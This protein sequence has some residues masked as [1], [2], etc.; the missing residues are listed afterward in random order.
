[1]RLMLLISALLVSSTALAQDQAPKVAPQPEIVEE[2]S[3][4]DD[5][6]VDEEASEERGTKPT[7][8]DELKQQTDKATDYIEK[9]VDEMEV[10]SQA[11]RVGKNYYAG[12]HLGLFDFI[13]LPKYG[14]NLGV[15]DSHSDMYELEYSRGSISG[16][17][18]FKHLISITEQRLSLKKRNY[19]RGGSFNV[20]YGVFYNSLEAGIG[21]E[22]IVPALQ[23][24]SYKKVID[25]QALGLS[26][27][28]ANTWIFANKLAVGVDWI[29]WSQ[30]IFKL[31]AEP[32]DFEFVENRDRG[33]I[34][35]AQKYLLYFPRWSILKVQV[36]LMF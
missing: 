19:F 28:I 22:I 31:K 2:E 21:K 8:L 35:R 12:V 14:V 3:E 33:A 26:A 34:R 36:G 15:L 24:Q 32:E 29:S 18:V 25:L 10:E 23:S 11:A 17:G 4:A 1:M 27:G 9:N 16:P 20:S 6:E 30:P 13:V 7:V 5:V